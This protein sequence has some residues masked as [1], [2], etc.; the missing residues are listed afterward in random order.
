[1]KIVD[2]TID[3]SDP[4]ALG[5]LYEQLRPYAVA[6]AQYMV[7]DLASAKDIFQDVFTKLCSKP[8]VFQSIK[9][10]YQWVYVSCHRAAIDHLRATKRH[11]ALGDAAREIFFTAP[12][13]P[14]V[15]FANQRTFAA[16]LHNFDERESAILGYLVVDGL[17][18][19]EI[20]G[21]M[22]VSERTIQRAVSEMNVKLDQLRRHHY[23]P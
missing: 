5:S 10:A 16:I 22:D 20:A 7:N 11:L 14:E 3:C 18:Q 8:I 19:K 17:T 4:Q 12:T 1:M 23:E 2:A 13:N 6:K 21:L 9:M 15:R